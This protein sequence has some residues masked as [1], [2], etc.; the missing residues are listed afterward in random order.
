MAFRGFG[1][2]QKKPCVTGKPPV[3]HFQ[4]K[5][6]NLLQFCFPECLE[7]QNLV[8]AIEE[9]R[10]KTATGGLRGDSASSTGR[11]ASGSETEAMGQ[12]VRHLCRAYV[13]GQ[14]DHRS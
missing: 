10:W 3:Q 14:E 9:L 13:A 12:C 11:K 4:L 1:Q 2:G 8:N 6:E 7:F 5:G